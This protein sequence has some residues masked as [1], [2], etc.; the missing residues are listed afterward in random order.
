MAS[1]CPRKRWR[2]MHGSEFQEIYRYI[3]TLEKRI[4]A[5]EDQMAGLPKV[6]EM[7]QEQEDALAQIAWDSRD[8]E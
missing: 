4:K 1:G 3:A 2:Y 6:L 7:T 8:A 5:L